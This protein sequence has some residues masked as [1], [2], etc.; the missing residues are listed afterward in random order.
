VCGIAGWF[1]DRDAAAAAAAPHSAR[2]DAMLDAIA[3]RGP[4]GRGTAH[5]GGA[6]LG[7]VRLSIIDVAGGAQPLWDTERRAAIVFNGE[8]YNYRELRAGLQARGQQFATASDTEVV[9]ALYLADGVGGLGKLRGMYAFAIWDVRQRRGVLARD[10]LGIKPLFLHREPGRL[11]FGSEAKA[12]LAG[13]V[14]ARLDEAALHLLLNFRYLP[15]ERS[16]FRGIR[17]LAP[18]RVLIWNDDGQVRE[19]TIP[20][21]Q[22]PGAQA[23]EPGR[24]PA[25]L[26]LGAIEDA[27][28]AHL[29]ADVQVGAYLSGGIDS[30]AVVALAR[31]AGTLPTFTLAVGDDPAEAANA[32]RTAALL[33]VD[34]AVATAPSPPAVSLPD[35][36]AQLEVPKVNAW[37]V[38]ALARHAAGHVKVVLSGLGGDELFY[39]Y[40]MHAILSRV[41][42]VGRLPGGVRR[43]AGGL[44]AALLRTGP[45]PW[46]EPRRMALMLAEAGD[47]PRVYGLLRNLWDSPELRRRLYGPRLLDQPLPDAFDELAAR[48][49]DA[50]DPVT[51]AA[52]FE[53]QEKMVNDLLWQ[54]DRVSMAQGLEVRVPFV[55]ATLAA[56]VAPLGRAALMP[57]GRRKGLLRD[58][59]SPILPAEILSRPK[60]G[61]QVDAGQFWH[62][63]LAPLAD[64]WL[65]DGE[66]RRH[67][68]FNPEFV[69]RLRRAPP[70]KGFRWHFFLLYLMLGTH[71]WATHFESRPAT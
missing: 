45:V 60:S 66:V 36:I 65:S 44:L 27:V 40:N 26:V 58:S 11:L 5:L 64:T 37:Q 10:P 6:V 35:L 50:P 20:A 55:D 3:H 54:E 8:I 19:T 2:I 24:A 14:D 16:L 7:H 57:R 23:P 43:A 56:R 59:L 61:F 33:G 48:W 71:L 32:T 12:L 68:L 29:V 62:N 15:G 30:A 41:E 70:R 46:S 34:N 38:A 1:D 53:W 25:A 17:Q 31:R 9:L 52:R 4:D 67:G 47:W 39:G 42:R 49:P 18:G 22:T 13:G 63:Q 69:R 51:A 28:A 21:A